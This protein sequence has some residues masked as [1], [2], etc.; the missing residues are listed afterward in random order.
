MRADLGALG[1]RLAA[2]HLEAKG[3]RVCDRNVR[4]PPW[5]EID[6]VADH[7]GVLALVEVRTRTGEGYG[8]AAGSLTPTK[9]R[10]MLRAALA[11]L[12]GLGN[13]PPQAR[14]DLV[15]VTFDRRGV[16]RRVEHLENVVEDV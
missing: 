9:R 8:G 15:A 10:R 6:L 4:V 11:Y 13:D 5:G 3:Y 12:S 1:E 2:A 7:G 14:I 16:L